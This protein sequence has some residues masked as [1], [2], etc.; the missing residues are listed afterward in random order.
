MI[1]LSILFICGG[2][3]ITGLILIGC[4]IYVLGYTAGSTDACK[5]RPEEFN[6]LINREV[7]RFDRLV[8]AKLRQDWD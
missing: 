7:A 2:F 5:K 8:D 3:L 6:E 1:T 4:W